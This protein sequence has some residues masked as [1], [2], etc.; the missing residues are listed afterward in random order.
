MNRYLR[1]SKWSI[2][3]SLSFC[4][5]PI[6]PPSQS[7]FHLSIRGC[8]CLNFHGDLHWVS[9]LWCFWTLMSF[10]CCLILRQFG[11]L[12][13]FI[14]VLIEAFYF[15][16]CLRSQLFLLGLLLCAFLLFSIVVYYWNSLSSSLS[17]VKSDAVSLAPDFWFAFIFWIMLFH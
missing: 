11:L 4:Y 2:S 10:D 16:C 5:S 13:I 3:L 6:E 9:H 7:D 1:L 14:P 17:S 8:C 12:F 15:C